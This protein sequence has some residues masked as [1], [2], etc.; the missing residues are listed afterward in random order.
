MKLLPYIPLKIIFVCLVI[1]ACTPIQKKD[2]Q[3]LKKENERLK[4]ELHTNKKRID[5]L[6]QL[7]FSTPQPRG[8]TFENFHITENRVGIF[9]RGITVEQLY[10]LLPNEQIKKSVGYGEFADDTYD[11][12]Q[13]YD[14]DGTLL[15]VLGTETNGDFKAKINSIVVKDPR[16]ETTENLGLNTTYEE[17]QKNYIIDNLFREETMIYLYLKYTGAWFL[18]GVNTTDLPN[19]GWDSSGS[20]NLPKDTK[21]DTFTIQ[22]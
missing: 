9:A 21:M 14:S 2:H 4:L 1:C 22:W 20:I 16:F 10:L 7:Q 5:S 18:F 15:L 17:L 6:L 12:Y 8:Y 13:I 19:S 3:A 11:E